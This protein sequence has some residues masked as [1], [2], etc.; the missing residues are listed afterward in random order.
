MDV[1]GRDDQVRRGVAGAGP[2]AASGATPVGAEL[3][4]SHYVP[5]R[6]MLTSKA[7]RP[8]IHLL[9]L[10]RGATAEVGQ[11]GKTTT[12]TGPA[13]VWLP[14]GSAEWLEVPA[15]ATAELLQLRAGVWHRYLPPSAEPAYL[16]L[17]AAGGIMA[18]PVEPDLVTTMSRSIAAIAAEI[19]SPARS[20]A[21][22]IMSAE[23]TLCVLRF[24]RLFAGATD[25]R[26]EEGSSAEILSRFRRLL[27][28]R[29]QQHL[30]VSDY[31]NLLGMTPDRLH[32]LCSRELKRSPSELIQQRLVKEA[33]TRL[34]AGTVAVKQ[35]A[36]ALGFKDT[37]YFSRFFRKHTGEAPGVWRR[38]VA[39]RVRAGRSRPT[40]NF[41]DWP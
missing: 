8:F 38:R 25:D 29:Y 22:S 7:A 11:P 23:L 17:E 32:A 21:A 28:E 14:A 34:E 36:F 12:F 10:H 35:I 4:T 33:A 13:I 40:L 16:A 1:S 15:G 26:D 27:E 39:A 31:A 18:R 30:R 9:C 2:A 37:A 20:G 24:W 3:I 19:A 41:A 5:R 6:W